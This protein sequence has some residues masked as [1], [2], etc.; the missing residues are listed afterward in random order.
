MVS[1]SYLVPPLL[2]GRAIW[3]P[4]I[5]LYV[6]LRSN[7]IST[8]QARAFF[9]PAAIAGSAYCAKA[10]PSAGSFWVP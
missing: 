9:A 6:N 8:R 1:V 7:Q 4:A 3:H 10:L 5:D 2:E